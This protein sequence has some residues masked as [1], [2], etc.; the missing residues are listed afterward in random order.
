MPTRYEVVIQITQELEF[1]VPDDMDRREVKIL[2][3]KKAKN[4]LKLEELQIQILSSDKVSLEEAKGAPKEV[5]RVNDDRTN[6]TDEDTDWI[7][8]QS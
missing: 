8:G 2:L 6:L 5:L 4:F 3:E 1:D 7:E